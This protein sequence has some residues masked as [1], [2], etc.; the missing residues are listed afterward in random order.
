MVSDG[1]ELVCGGL[2]T[3]AGGRRLAAG[4]LSNGGAPAGEGGDDRVRELQEMEWR[5]MAC[6]IWAVGARMRGLRGELPAAATMA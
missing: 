1:P 5:V 4:L 3:D 2:A 6:S